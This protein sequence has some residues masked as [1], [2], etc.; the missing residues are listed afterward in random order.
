MAI[1]VLDVGKSNAKLLVLDEAGAGGGARRALAG[2]RR[3]AGPA[4][5]G[6]EAVRAEASEADV[7]AV[8]ASRVLA[9]PSFVPGSGPCMGR[10]GR[11]VGDPGPEPARRAALA[12]VY[13]ALTVEL[14]LEKLGAAG[15]LL[16]EGSFHANRAFC[17][18]LAALRPSQP[19]H[20]MSDPSGTARGAWLLA[21]WGKAE[22]APPTLSPASPP[23]AVPGLA[24]YRAAWREQ[25]V[26][27]A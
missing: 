4:L 12:A 21:H 25:A 15:P 23:L 20:I 3:A 6:P 26:V 16:I 1:A 11:I 24:T 2:L 19:V 18:L 14:M 17:G 27:R 22:A 9:L 10:A 8:V 13:G 7:E 5:A